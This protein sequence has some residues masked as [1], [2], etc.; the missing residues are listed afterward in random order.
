MNRRDRNKKKK[1]I[2][3]NQFKDLLLDTNF[4]N[5]QIIFTQ[6]IETGKPITYVMKEKDR[7]FKTLIFPVF[8]ENNSA[9]SIAICNRDITLQIEA[10]EK[11]KRTVF[12]LVTA[13]EDERYRI[14]RDLHDEVGQRMTGLIFEL[15]TIKESLT[16]ENNIS[17]NDI[18]NVIQNFEQVLKHIR[19]II[20]Q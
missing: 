1:E 12:K 17:I 4:Q 7:W 5:F 8:K 2:I 18:D 11:L 10:E 20:Y 19:Q 3:G 16:K 14:S 6:V 15:K 9:L 13:Q